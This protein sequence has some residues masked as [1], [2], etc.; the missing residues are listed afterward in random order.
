MNNNMPPGLG[1]TPRS[2]WPTNQVGD[3]DRAI[4]T[5]RPTTKEHATVL[6]YLLDRIKFSEDEMRKFYP[7]WRVSERKYQ[8]YITLP[9]WEKQL[10][11]MNDL[12]AP[13][14]T[15]SLTIPYTFATISTIVTYLIHTF[16][17]QKPM[18]QVGTTKGEAAMAARHM[19]TVLQYNADVQRLIKHMFQFFQDGQMYGV[20]IMRNMW[21]V[22]RRKRTIWVPEDGTFGAQGTGRMVKKR[23]D[24]IAYEGN[25]IAC[26]DPYNFLPD[27]RVPMSEC[28]REGEFVFWKSYE[29]RHKLKKMEAQGKVRFVDAAGQMQ[30][31]KWDTTS[32][33]FSDRGLLAQGEAEPG[34]LPRHDKVSQN[35]EICQGTVEIIPAELGLGESTVPEKWLFTIA[36]RRQV[37]QAEPLALDH[38][39]HPIIVSEPYT[40]GYSFGQP[41]MADYLNQIQDGLSWLINSHMD[42]VRTALNNMFVI[43]PSKVEIQDLKEPG[44]GKLIRLK[45]SAYGHDVRT[46]INQL[47]VYDVTT[48]H[49]KDFQLFMSIGDA[50]SSITDN[51]RGLQSAGS[52]K[53]ATEVRTAGEASASRLAAQSRLISA[54]AIVDLTMQMSLN[55]QQNLSEEFFMEIV[56]QDGKENSIRIKPE[57]I[58]GDFHFPV[59][60]G[61]L[62]LDRVALL[63]V[64]REILVGVGQDPTLRQQ[65][66]TPAIFEYVAKLGGAKNIE[67][68]KIQP[69]SPEAIQAQVQ[70]GNMIPASEAINSLGGNTPGINENPQERI[71]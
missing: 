50:L 4:D 67:Q 27:P 42:N 3:T 29:G 7:R 25:K 30:S 16:A 36:N 65:Y 39:M 68:F 47:Q 13:P 6:N 2:E 70:A 14:K 51:L 38:D 11:D 31:G 33:N 40:M 63:D 61:T 17:G 8:A 32:E 69:N 15:V 59:H 37:I 21:T 62:P 55:L 52:R 35:V 71:Q 22:D 49:V 20:S 64:W 56:G 19:E 24:A 12:G 58:V 54:Q 57:H 9:D 34:R 44:A 1:S 53:T 26:I 10:K 28:A 41:G 66:S 43:D 5:L 60:D 45:K 48:N 23:E 46:A 18:F